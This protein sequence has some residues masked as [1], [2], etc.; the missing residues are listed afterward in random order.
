M[1]SWYRTHIHPTSIGGDDQFI[2]YTH[3][4]YLNWWGWPVHI[5]HTSTPPQLV[6]MTSS[7]RTHIHP[8]S[9]GGDDQFTSYTHL[10]HLNWWGWPVHIVHT[11]TPPQLVGMTSSYRTPPPYLKIWSSTG[12][13]AIEDVSD[14]YRPW[15]VHI[16]LVHPTSKYDP[17]SV[18]SR[19][20]MYLTDID[21]DQLI[22][23]SS[24]LH[25]N[26]IPN[27]CNC[28][29]GCTWPISTTTSSH[30]TAP[31]YLEIWS[32]IGVIAIKDVSI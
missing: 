22:S 29:W 31:P 11:F 3:S 28:D 15:L 12:V 10:P 9:I 18:Y 2:S 25:R 13:I 1:F 20:R 32:S 21:N 16:V 23:Y 14:R 26:M 6:G 7:Y 8:T 19:L 4:P 24:T 17:Q 27:Q 30:R 5:V